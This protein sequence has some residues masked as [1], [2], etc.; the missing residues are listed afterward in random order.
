VTPKGPVTLAVGHSVDAGHDT[1]LSK[2]VGRSTAFFSLL[3]LLSVIGVAGFTALGVWQLERRT[4]KL[5]LID[6]VEQRV[7]AAPVPIPAP[8]VWPRINT[9][10]DAYK[11]VSVT[12]RFMHDRETLV[13]AATELGTGYWVL[14]PL[15][16]DTGAAVLVNRGF[17]SPERRDQTSR[18]DGDPAGPVQVTGLIRMTEPKGSFLQTNVPAADRW[19]SR[20][21]SAIAR[22]R[23]LSNTAPF[24]I[25][26][27]ASPN[28][29]GWP[30]GGLTVIKF[31]N[32]HLSYAL[33][34]FALAFLA[35]GAGVFV[36]RDEW[37][38]RQGK[39][40]SSPVLK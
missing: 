22:A 31:P 19:Y 23:G 21:V 40:H 11:R 26:A 29:G 28:P 7:H 17:V 33:T 2:P 37:Q 4:W 39:L 10:D 30:V 12:G 14:T 20:D 1:R 32:N 36:V 15:R 6:Q 35:G 27:D 16:T 25:D 9:T 18:R 8:D 5:G 13:R 3:V 38:L 34:W 24:F